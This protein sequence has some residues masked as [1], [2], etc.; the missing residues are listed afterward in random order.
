MDPE[1]KRQL[2]DRSEQLGLRPFEDTP[3][4]TAADNDDGAPPEPPEPS[5]RLDDTRWCRCGRC[6][7]MPT[8][9]ECVCCLEVP[10]VASKAGNRCI[11]DHSDFFGGILN[12]VVLQIAYRMRA[13]ELNDMELIGQRS[14]HKKYRY[15]AYRQFVWW[16]WRRLGRGNRTVLPACV[17]QAIRNMYPSDEYRGFEAL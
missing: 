13:M 2:L 8:A 17:V 4:K 14:T 6:Q 16:I 15:V 9:R 11:T 12:P 7:L 5:A 10:K 1:L 3:R